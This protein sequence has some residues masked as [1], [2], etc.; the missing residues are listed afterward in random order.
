MNVVADT[1]T[2]I[3]LDD[4]KC[5]DRC[6]G[7]SYAPCSGRCN[8]C[9]KDKIIYKIGSLKIGSKKGDFGICAALE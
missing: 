8:V 7:I 9:V 2:F 1:F 6:G 5:G 4:H 3:I